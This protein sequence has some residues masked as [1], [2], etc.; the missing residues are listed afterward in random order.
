MNISEIL[1]QFKDPNTI[2]NMSFSAKMTASLVVTIL[3]M[4]ITFA[5]LII[6]RYSTSLLSHI[7]NKAE[8]KKN[9][10]QVVK[11]EA[12]LKNVVTKE[13][14]EIN[15]ELISVIT[16]AIASS[17]NTSIHNI[18]VSNIVR[19]KDSTPAWG[20]AGRSNLINSKVNIKK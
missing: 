16:A 13:D 20:V 18:V 10:I 19:V 17:L 14:D 8:N 7:V 3:G 12:V 1:Q 5:A 11:K 9:N 6:I 4:G 2:M 15:E